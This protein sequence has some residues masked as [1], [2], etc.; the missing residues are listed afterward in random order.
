MGEVPD[1]TAG[2]K[3]SAERRRRHKAKS[4]ENDKDTK[5]ELQ[6]ATPKIKLEFVGKY[7]MFC[8]RIGLRKVKSE[9]LYTESDDAI[10]TC[11]CT[12]PEI[13]A[14]RS[15]V[16]GRGSSN[17]LATDDA[18]KQALALIQTTGLLEMTGA[19]LRIKLK[20]DF[21][22]T[23]PAAATEQ[24]PA[25]VETCPEV[26]VFLE[27]V[28]EA[29][30]GKIEN[31]LCYV[32]LPK[33]R[34]MA[35]D[36]KTLILTKLGNSPEI[37]ATQ[38][39][40]SLFVIF[41]LEICLDICYGFDGHYSNEVSIAITRLF[42]LGIF[43]W[44]PQLP[45]NVAEAA[46]AAVARLWADRL[47][48]FLSKSR[49]EC[50]LLYRI[51]YF[52]KF[53]V[54]PVAIPTA[55][56]FLS[57]VTLSEFELV[58]LEI[59]TQTFAKPAEL[60]GSA[61]NGFSMPGSDVDAVIL[62]DSVTE[63]EGVRKL[64]E[65]VEL[66]FPGKFQIEKVEN[67]RVPI[68]VLKT[69]NVE[70]NFSFNRPVVLENS[71]LLKNYAQVNPLVREF[72]VTVKKWAKIRDIADALNG[73]L[74]SYSWSLLVIFFLQKIGLLPV[75]QEGK[76]AMR[77]WSGVRLE[78]LLRD[79]FSLYSCELDFYACVISV[80]SGRLLFGEK[81]KVWLTIEDPCEEGRYLGP[82]ARG[83]DK[84][85]AEL[86]RGLVLLRRGDWAEIFSE[87]KERGQ[88]WKFPAGKLKLR[89]CEEIEEMFEQIK[90]AR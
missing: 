5:A 36:Q 53:P 66:K 43:A 18:C 15:T 13:A 64:A 76:S 38:K 55:F 44:F 23:I 32:I 77:D 65:A 4:T 11:Q 17:E 45:K 1:N 9:F 56:S 84:I 75:L 89:S 61:V 21:E 19:R 62:D 87:K 33:L 8:D 2:N 25:L 85:I 68:L 79:F 82:S 34:K 35:P 63:V 81:R 83:Q 10:L 48:P 46:A 73:T 42:E 88:G 72:A 7:M 49:F 16:T 60:Y 22:Y 58:N 70:M 26:E 90:L 74:S 39:P 54:P 41:M 24:S 31:H 20:E 30:C 14:L 40:T 52:E 37:L 59:V 12:I 50:F 78:V 67:A 47:L 86:R 51:G 69:E 80:K 28:E 29:D 6:A 71:R 57:E 3:G 27:L